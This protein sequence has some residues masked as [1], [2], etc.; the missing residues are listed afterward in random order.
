MLNVRHVRRRAF[1]M[2]MSVATMAALLIVPLGSAAI[3]A[4]TS[5][6]CPTDEGGFHNCVLVISGPESV[7]TGVPFTVQVLVTTNG[8]TVANSDPCASKVPVTLNISGESPYHDMQTVNASAGIATFSFTIPTGDDATYDLSATAGTGGGYAPTTSSPTTNCGSYFY[9]SDTR[10]L[11]AVTI[12]DGQPIAPCP[13]NSVCT[14][15]FNG[16]GSAATL[17]S[18]TGTFTNVLWQ[19]DPDL[20]SSCGAPADNSGSGPELRFDNTGASTPKTIVFTLAAK[21]VTK[22][23]GQFNI[24]WNGYNAAGIPVVGVL[25]PCAKNDMGPCVL[26]KKSNK[27]N[28]GF[29]GVLAPPGSFDPGGY[30]R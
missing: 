28:V 1:A 5:T 16:G 23:I 8:T 21:Y 24:C 26:F 25:P 18:D 30:V 27:Q 29:F 9:Q 15:T 13:D 2:L 14:Q 22:G 17:I 10:T 7:Q 19:Q 11:T 12:P 20:A 4:S 6:T 3:A